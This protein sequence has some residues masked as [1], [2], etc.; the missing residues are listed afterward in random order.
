MSADAG[1]NM[2]AVSVLTPRLLGEL[3]IAYN[4][5]STAGLPP[6]QLI[7]EFLVVGE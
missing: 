3:V 5:R 2:P 7:E 1:E 4:L 6:K